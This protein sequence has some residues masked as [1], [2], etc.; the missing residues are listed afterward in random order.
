[1]RKESRILPYFPTKFFSR[2]EAVSDIGKVLREEE[3]CQTRI[4]MGLRD[5]QL[6]KRDK[7]GGKWVLVPLKY[8]E[9]P[10]VELTSSPR[11]TDSGS[12]APGRPCQ[13]RSDKRGR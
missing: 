12:P 10:Q 11:R 2:F 8:D 4:K 13:S 5:I 6:F 1:M 9:L 3:S 7:A